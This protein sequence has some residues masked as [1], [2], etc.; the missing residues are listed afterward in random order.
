MVL[1]IALFG[2]GKGTSIH[3]A[4]NYVREQLLQTVNVSHV[5][6]LE[7]ENFNDLENEY[8]TINFVKLKR[9]SVNLE[10][11]EQFE[12]AYKTFW[13]SAESKPDVIFL[14]GWN[15]ILS[16]GLLEYYRQEG[17]VV[18]NMHPALPGSFV[19][20]NAIE[21]TFKEYTNGV[22][23]STGSMVHVVTEELDSGKVIAT[24]SVDLVPNV[25]KS[26]EELRELVK[27]HEKPLIIDSLLFLIKYKME[28]SLNLLR[29]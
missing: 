8:S 10:D 1:N 13:K 11:R 21:Q 22:C 4:L 14:L 19:G 27:L 23:F 26:I 3:F 25:I 20:A 2:S 16:P 29:S 12:N 28:S 24:S 9:S 6:C 15:Y 18:V 5:V 17:I 7:N